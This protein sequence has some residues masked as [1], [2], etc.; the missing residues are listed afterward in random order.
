MA[1]NNLPLE[2]T[3]H[4]IRQIEHRY[5]GDLAAIPRCCRY[6]HQ[7]AMP[8]LYSSFT[9]RG[10]LSMPLFLRTI[11]YRPDLAR[12]VKTFSIYLTIARD[13]NP[14]GCPDSDLLRS[15]KP[16]IDDQLEDICPGDALF[17]RSWSRSLI[18][19]RNWDAI[20][21]LVICLLPNLSTLTLPHYADQDTN[22]PHGLRYL[23]FALLEGA[24]KQFRNCPPK[25]WKNWFY[26]TSNRITGY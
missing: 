21:A 14:S 25:F 3:V 4:V 18:N 6:L 5:P 7:V 1:L 12:Y 11:L 2:I 22:G 26:G 15:L 24:Q 19:H 13:H 16:M 20:S 9:E 17:K 10:V 23:T 8:I